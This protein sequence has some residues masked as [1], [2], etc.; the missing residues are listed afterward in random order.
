M[1]PFKVL[2]PVLIAG[3]GIGWVIS[4]VVQKPP[5]PTLLDYVNLSQDGKCI[6]SFKP[7]RENF[8]PKISGCT[9]GQEQCCI[10]LSEKK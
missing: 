4:G 7:D 6:V 8:A 9:G 10:Q 2:A 1:I 3:T 5:K